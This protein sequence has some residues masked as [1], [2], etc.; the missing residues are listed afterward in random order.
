METSIS[1]VPEMT[2]LILALG[3]AGFYGLGKRHCVP[4]YSIDYARSSLGQSSD[5][6]IVKHRKM[7]MDPMVNWKIKKE[8]LKVSV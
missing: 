3:D 8:K 1:Y 5:R 6:S 7:V 2:D 4:K